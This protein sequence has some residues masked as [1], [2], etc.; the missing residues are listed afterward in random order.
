ML[1]VFMLRVRFLKSGAVF[2]MVCFLDETG[3]FLLQS[4]CG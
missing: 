1:R 4:G 3:A 2:S